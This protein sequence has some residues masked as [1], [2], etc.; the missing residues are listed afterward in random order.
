MKNSPKRPDG[1]Y[2]AGMLDVSFQIPNNRIVGSAADCGALTYPDPTPSS[3]PI[4]PFS[5]SA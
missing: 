1:H 5:T 3:D 4:T 2:T